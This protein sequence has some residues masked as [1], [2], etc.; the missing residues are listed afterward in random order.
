MQLFKTLFLN[1]NS[2]TCTWPYMQPNLS[3]VHSRWASLC[4][5][6][7]SDWWSTDL[8]WDAFYNSNCFK[9]NGLASPFE[10]AQLEQFQTLQQWHQA[11]A[12]AKTLRHALVWTQQFRCFWGLLRIRDSRTEQCI[13][14]SFYLSFHQVHQKRTS[15]NDKVLYR[16]LPSIWSQL[17]WTCRP[18]KRLLRSA[19]IM[20]IL[21]APLAPITPPLRL[22]FFVVGSAF[23]GISINV[24]RT[25]QSKIFCLE[26]SSKLSFKGV[27]VTQGLL[28]ILFGVE[29]VYNWASHLKHPQSI[30]LDVDRAP[31]KPNFIQ[32]F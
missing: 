18:P 4:A 16:F 14:S 5:R 10:K 17:P 32:F 7:S 19:R 27:L 29:E 28:W 2:S 8:L 23:V 12:L 26:L 30:E 31:E 3:F 24:G 20:V 6:G 15:D 13:M 21:P 22:H 9:P 25:R 1:R 11:L